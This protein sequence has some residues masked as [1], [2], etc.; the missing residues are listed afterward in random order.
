VQDRRY[1][2]A[3]LTDHASVHINQRHGGQEGLVVIGEHKRGRR[4]G[5]LQGDASVTLFGGGEASSITCQAG[6]DGR[7]THLIV[8]QALTANGA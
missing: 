7:L 4:L 2:A 8:V 3:S 5:K 1:D 6:C